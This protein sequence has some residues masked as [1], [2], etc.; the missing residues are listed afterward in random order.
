MSSEY[1]TNFFNVA[2]RP[3]DSDYFAPSR[4]ELVAIMHQLSAKRNEWIAKAYF[5]RERGRTEVAEFCGWV[6]N[7]Y[8]EAHKMLADVIGSDD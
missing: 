8:Q 3:K 4:K 1:P 2:Y 5:E 7:A 6:A